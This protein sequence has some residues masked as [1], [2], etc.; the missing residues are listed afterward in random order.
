MNVQKT[1]CSSATDATSRNSCNLVAAAK[2]RDDATNATLPFRGVALLHSM[3]GNLLQI[4]GGF[5]LACEKQLG[6]GGRAEGLARSP[7]SVPPH[8]SARC[9]PAT[10]ARHRWRQD[11]DTFQKAQRNQR[12]ASPYQGGT[13]P[14]RARPIAP[15]GNSGPP[16]G[17]D[18]SASARSP[19]S[20]TAQ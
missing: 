15:R 1:A 20:G 10:T 19:L 7:C 14:H 9:P 16:W 5:A 2:R 3:P 8:R 17:R 12:L 4:A 18:G 11:G 6:G 13:R